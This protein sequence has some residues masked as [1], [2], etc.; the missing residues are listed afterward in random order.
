MDLMYVEAPPTEQEI[1]RDLEYSRLAELMGRD[2]PAPGPY[3]HWDDLRYRTPPDGLSREEWWFFLRLKRGSTRV[4]PLAQADMDLFSF[5]L[6]DGVQRLLHQVDQRCAGRI[7]MPEVVTADGAARDHYLVNSLMEEA[8]RSSQLEGASTSRRVAKEMLLTGRAPRD[9]SET[10]ILN[11]YRASQFMREAVDQ[12]L[13]PDLVL[14]L[15]RILTEGTLDNPSAAGRL[16]LPDEP[17][18]AVF[19]RDD[20]PVPVHVPPPA[21]E[22]PWRLQALCDFAN[23]GDEDGDFIHP[24]IRAILVHF[25]LAYD[26]PFEDGNGRMARNLFYWQMRRHGYWLTEYLSI[27]RILWEA[28]AQYMR[29]FMLTETDEGDTTYF[30]LHQLEVISKAI[31][32]MDRYLERKTQEIREL[33]TM[34]R[35]GANF[36]PRQLDLLS[37]ALRDRGRTFTISA[38][39]GSHSVTHE[40]A[41]KDLLG[42]EQ[43]GLLHRQG[44]SR[45]LYFAAPGDLEKRLDKQE[46]TA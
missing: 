6:P 14:E 36:N 7:A 16:Q 9:R 22:L 12:E 26:H 38:H 30:L 3:P 24:V 41:R 45:R 10:M 31:A 21:G 5:N 20:E 42:L 8:I 35:D 46:P 27:S 25:Q 29:A 39:A 32:E 37:Q 33:E 11:N 28:P 23:A 34:L 43:L 17:R 18:V 4:V 2:V 1:I 40:T 19:D 13:T 15:H 44:T